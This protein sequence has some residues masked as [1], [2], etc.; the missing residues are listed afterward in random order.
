MA[1]FNVIET[2]F[3]GIGD[4]K[5]LDSAIFVPSFTWEVSSLFEDIAAKST[6]IVY[7]KDVS[8]PS[9]TFEKEE[10]TGSSLKYKFA[11]GV[12]Y[13]DIR[14]TF[15]DTTGILPYLIKWRKSVWEEGGGLKTASE[16]KKESVIK[17]Y[18]QTGELQQT[19]TLTGSWPSVIKHGDLTYTSSDFKFVDVTIT[20]DWAEES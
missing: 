7:A 20:Y 3:K 10:Y 16:Y 2:N 6:A 4:N 5:A 1:G 11:S 14:V 17:V 9:V 15:Y 13:D 12:I 19:F 18:D 8:L